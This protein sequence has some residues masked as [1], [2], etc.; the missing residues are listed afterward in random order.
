MKRTLPLLLAA[1]ALPA[2]AESLDPSL[3]CKSVEMTV[4][5]YAGTSTLA[6]FPVLV[7]LSRAGGFSF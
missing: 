3:F 1:L 5:G 6:N 4:S 7:R 2:G